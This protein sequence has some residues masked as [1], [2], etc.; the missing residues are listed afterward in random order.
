MTVINNMNLKIHIIYN[1]HE[2]KFVLKYIITK[3]K[4]ENILHRYL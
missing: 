2:I 1:S 3:L 4:K